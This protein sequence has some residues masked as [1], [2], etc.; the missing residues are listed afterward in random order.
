MYTSVVMVKI[1]KLLDLEV[2][3]L[4]PWF[5]FVGLLGLAFLLLIIISAFFHLSALIICHKRHLITQKLL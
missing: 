1:S 5:L 2:L 3:V 4:C